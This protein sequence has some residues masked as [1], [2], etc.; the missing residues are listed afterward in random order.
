MSSIDAAA[1]ALLSSLDTLLETSIAPAVGGAVAPQVGTQGEPPGTAPPVTLA[2]PVSPAAS[3]PASLSELALVLDAIMGATPAAPAAV[4]GQAPLLAEAPAPDLPQAP[5][6]ASAGSSVPT[7]PLRAASAEA[8]QAMSV[9]ELSA[10]LARTV[11][12][13]GLFYESHLAE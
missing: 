3:E 8:T 2:D 13:S 10:A 1:V 11:S 4:T 5:E 12:E 7:S 6:A 9:H